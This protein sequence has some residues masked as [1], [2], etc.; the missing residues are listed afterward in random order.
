MLEEPEMDAHSPVALRKEM[1]IEGSSFRSSVLP[2][3]VLVWK[4]RSMPPPS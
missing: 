4:R 1:L 2:D 3:S